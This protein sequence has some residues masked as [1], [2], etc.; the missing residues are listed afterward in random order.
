MTRARDVANIDGILTTTGDT[1]YA[2]S[3][4]TPARLGIGSTDQVLKV[5]GGVPTWA[6]PSAGKILQVVTGTYSTNFSTTSTTPVDSG[7][8]VTITPTSATSTI[9]IWHNGNYYMNAGATS[10]L[11]LRIVRGATAI[12][13]YNSQMYDNNNDLHRGEVS[14]IYVDS[15]ATTS[16]TTYKI[17]IFNDITA[18]IG[19]QYNNEES[20]FIL[21]EVSA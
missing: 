20:R 21:M 15:P 10:S 7:L 16:A 4:G 19:A 17:Q 14:M 8:S 2:S 12:K 18:T 1:F 6:S 9:A 11:N 5:S 3:G 13:T